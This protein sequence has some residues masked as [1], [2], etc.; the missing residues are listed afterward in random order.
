MLR[1]D[2]IL[3]PRCFTPHKKLPL[4]PKEEA[5]CVRCQALL[6]RYR[7]G[8][9]Y[10]LLTLSTLS[11]L[12]LLIANV[13][14]LLRINFGELSARTLLL[15]AILSLFDKG[16]VFISFFSLLVLEVFPWLLM[17]TLSLF[18]IL[19]LLR[20]GKVIAKGSLILVEIFRRWSMLDI[21]F[22]AI[23]VAMIK[24]YQYAQIHFGV[25]FWA[26][27][28]FVLLEIYVVKSIRIEELWELWERRYE[29]A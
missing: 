25:A 28:I 24:V 13:S 9:E 15:E 7:S 12:C 16:F 18:S 8:L 1:K 14:P 29:M 11:L 10:L 6:Y 19:V 23:L 20:R 4:A 27:G 17:G 26:L 21:F 3:C 22:I 5:R 2:I